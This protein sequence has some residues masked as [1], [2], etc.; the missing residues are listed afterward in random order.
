MLIEM[1]VLGRQPYGKVVH[2]IE[3][4][5]LTIDDWPLWRSLRLAALAESPHAFGSKLSDWQ[6]EGD[7]ESRWRDRLGIPD[8]HNLVA[9]LD[10]TPAG[11][12]SGIPGADPDDIEVISVWVSPEAR[13]RQVGDALLAAIEAWARH[14]SARSLM[15]AVAPRNEEAI[16]LYTRNG[17]AMT[18]ELGDLMDD[19]VSHEAVMEKPLRPHGNRESPVPA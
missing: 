6:G 13:G 14:R 15:L 1:D 12:A 18:G 4:R 3:L 17:F 8:S 2:M 5:V 11:M 10:G 16:R 9:F 19:G 7:Q